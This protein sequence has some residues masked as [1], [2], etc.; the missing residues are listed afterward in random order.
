MS[1]LHIVNALKRRDF[2]CLWS[3]SL[4][5][6]FAMNMQMIARGWLVYTMTSSAMD[7][8]WVTLSF[9]VPQVFFSLWGGVLADRFRKRRILVSAQLLNCV[10]TLFMATIIVTENVTFWD[11]IWLGMF[12]GTVLAFS[13]P[14]RHAFV[15][16]LVPRR[17]IFTA[18]ALHTT[19]MNFARI[20]GPVIAGF[21]IAWVASGDTSSMR[22]VGIVYYVI[23]ALY[24]V[25]AVTMLFVHNPGAPHPRQAT[26][27]LAD[28][29]EGVAYVRA[30]PP[31]FGL[32]MLSIAAFLFGMP[33][34]TL[35]PAFNEDVLGGGSDDLGLLMS[36]M[37]AGAIIG[38]LLLAS[39]GDLRH[40]GAWLIAT[41][42]G[43]AAAT[44]A[45]GFTSA[46]PYSM[47]VV[48]VFG[49]MSA[50]NMALNRGL[51]QSQVAMR[52]RGRVMSIDMMSHGL[53]PLGMIPLGFIADTFGV[54]SALAVSGTLF[55][56]AVGALKWLSAS[57]RGVG[58]PAVAMGAT[59]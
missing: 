35:L 22:G 57:V 51:I 38:S 2:L 12:N 14:A 10:A 20:L 29:L 50:W 48:A 44:A 23:A 37:G 41:C 58:A 5:A 24:L 8:A 7:L 15:P 1:S 47:A 4:G 25:A 46:V 19:G 43:W 55:A 11:F 28:L 27:P 33:L 40:K 13:I 30:H 21:L 18:M 26:S 49:W 53:M 59:R 39:V 36:A 45:L 34:N 17:L 9:M 16:D 31:V 6:S 52:M 3:G 42:F 56:I 54:A 32:I